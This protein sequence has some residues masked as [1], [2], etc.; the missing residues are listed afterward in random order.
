MRPRII[1][2][3]RPGRARKSE[4]RVISKR[5]LTKG[6]EMTYNFECFNQTGRKAGALCA[7]FFLLAGNSPDPA[8]T[9]ESACSSCPQVYTATKHFQ[10]GLSSISDGLG[11]LVPI[12]L[13]PFGGFN[14][15]K[16]L[17]AVSKNNRRISHLLVR[18]FAAVDR[19]GR[20][21]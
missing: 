5:Y 21:S 10:E 12:F 7:I 4:P 6:D 18:G 11:S 20:L 15:P 8:N 19:I 2:G 16:L 3:E 17:S 13:S 14:R 9:A 1:L